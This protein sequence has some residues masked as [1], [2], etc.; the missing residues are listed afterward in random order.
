MVLA[1]IFLPVLSS[2]V[3]APK[4]EAE[5]AKTVAPLHQRIDQTVAAGN[6]I[7]VAQQAGDAEFVRRIYL[8]L[9]GSIPSVEETRNFLADADAK[10]RLKLVDSLLGSRAFTRHMATTFDVWFMERRAAKHV[11]DLEF[12]N[13]L[14]DSFAKNKPYDQLVH[15][16]LAADGT[17]ERI[18]PAARFYLDRD[19]E[20]NLLTRDVGVSFLAGIFSARSAM[21]IQILLTTFSVSTTGFTLFSIVLICS[22]LTKRSRH[23]LQKKPR[24]RLLTNRY[25]LKWLRA[26]FLLCPKAK[27]SW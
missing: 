21:T 1:V 27:T 12:R 5:A 19:A 7:P 14:I 2:I 26:P 22:S 16:I 4:V 9:T 15:E 20:P 17:E 8:D 18:R 13:Y 6:F 10:K 11:K 3:A 24:E 25:L 23:C